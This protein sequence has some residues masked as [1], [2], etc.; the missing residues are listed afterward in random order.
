M[1]VDIQDVEEANRLLLAALQAAAVDP[2]TGRI[3]LDLVT[4][5]ISSASRKDFTARRLA[6]RN[7]ITQLDKI[8]V[9]WVEAYRA[10]NAQSDVL[11]T[12]T[13][14]NRVISDLVDEGMIHVNGRSNADKIIRKLR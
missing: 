4:T 8:S 1:T 12:E 14:F 3:D 9:T 13:E 5:G 2:R 11:M 6:V 7:I 10:F